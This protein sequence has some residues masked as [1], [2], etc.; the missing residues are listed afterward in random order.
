MVGRNRAAPQRPHQSACQTSVPWRRSCAGGGELG[1]FGHGRGSECTRP[2]GELPASYPC[3]C[4]AT[5]MK[6]PER[7]SSR[8][9]E[10]TPVGGDFTDLA[11][12]APALHARGGFTSERW[13]L[14][15]AMEYRV[16]TEMLTAVHSDNAS[17]YR[18]LLKQLLLAQ[19]EHRVLERLGR[20]SPAIA[21]L[22]HRF[23]AREEHALARH[24]YGFHRNASRAAGQAPHG[25]GRG[26]GQAN[27]RRAAPG[28]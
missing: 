19:P 15:A 12:G 10:S 11:L 25:L 26:V 5:K 2:N 27:A 16:G 28:G 20:S 3:P 1:R 18:P 23:L 14:P 9:S 24:T 22:A 17:E 13:F 4:H 6:C 7:I 21:Q 8:N